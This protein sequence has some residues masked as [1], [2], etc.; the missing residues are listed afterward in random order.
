M[1][2]SELFAGREADIEAMQARLAKVAAAEGLPLAI[3]TRTYNS[4]FAQEL[5]KWAESRGAGDPFRR[6]VYRAYFVDGSNIALID[7]LIRIAE[8]VGLPVDEAREVL[9][10]RSFA[11]SVDADWQRAREMRITAVPT[12]I[13]DGKRLTGFSSYEDFMRLIGKG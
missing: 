11:S 4:R 3:R 7:E 10:E 8:S 13:C 12:H 2:L 6:A 9:S 5:G 1:E